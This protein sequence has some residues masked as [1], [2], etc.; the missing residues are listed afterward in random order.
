[1]LKQHYTVEGSLGHCV[2]TNMRIVLRLVYMVRETVEHTQGHCVWTNMR[3]VL[4]LVY[5]EREPVKLT[6]R[7]CC[8][9]LLD[10]VW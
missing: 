4:R 7:I 1:M 6:H 2:W 8:T 9:C 5:M 3:I 10:F